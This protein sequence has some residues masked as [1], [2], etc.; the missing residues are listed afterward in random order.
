MGN[1]YYTIILLGGKSNRFKGDVPK[2]FVNICGVPIFEKSAT[3]FAFH[4]AMEAIVLVFPQN[5]N[6]NKYDKSI[7]RI[8]KYS[9]TI[10]ATGG[11]KRGDSVYN[12]LLAIKDDVLNHQYDEDEICVLIH[13]GARPYISKEIIDRNI[14][15]LNKISKDTGIVTAIRSTDSIRMCANSAL[16]NEEDKHIINSNPLNREDIFLIQ[17]PQAFYFKNILKA[18][19]QASESGLS[20]T[21][22]AQVA[23]NAGMKIELVKGGIE[24]KKITYLKDLPMEIR[25]G[26]G[27]DVH[28]LVPGKGLVLCGTPVPCNKSFLGHSDA[29]VPVHAIMDALLGAAAK[30][31]IGTHFPDSDFKYKDASSMDLLR[32]V[33][34]MLEDWEISNID[35]TII[36]ER[37]KIKDYI[38]TM[39][40]NLSKAL[41]LEI[42]KINVKATTT[43]GLGF[44]GRE[45]GAS[46]FATCIIERGN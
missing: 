3:P 14:E 26:N 7:L 21:D 45:E 2:Q 19:E 17:T 5:V 6:A 44:E 20:F 15:S 25:I 39:R 12:G 43:E 40:E 37:P 34:D 35:V 33:K 46:A 9:R 13:D 36:M 38:Y 24:N 10:L 41:N 18:Y 30:G 27:Y 23:E 28:R 16:H 1:K 22:D 29:D 8:N 11:K 31:D 42:E 32:E 4:K